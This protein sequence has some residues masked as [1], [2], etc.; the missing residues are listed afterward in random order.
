M[1]YVGGVQYHGGKNLH[2]RHSNGPLGHRMER[3]AYMY[4]THHLNNY[5]YNNKSIGIMW[6]FVW[7]P[8]KRCFWAASSLSS[9]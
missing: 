8:F 3:H 1:M 9:L 2:Y 4:G 5:H 7:D 6:G